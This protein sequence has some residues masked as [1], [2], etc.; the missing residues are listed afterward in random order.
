MFGNLAK[1]QQF[2]EKAKSLPEVE[3]AREEFIRLMVESGETQEKAENQATVAAALGSSV[4]ISD[5]LYRIKTAS[6]FKVE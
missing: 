1:Y 2:K 6:M 3:V 5:K 4:M